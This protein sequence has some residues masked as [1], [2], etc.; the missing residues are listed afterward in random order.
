MFAV[1]KFGSESNIQMEVCIIYAL[2]V[3][4]MHDISTILLVLLNFFNKQFVY[5][6]LRLNLKQNHYW[7]QEKENKKKGNVKLNKKNTK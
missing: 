7:H 3:H 5:K 6:Q 4:Y 2:Y 1:A